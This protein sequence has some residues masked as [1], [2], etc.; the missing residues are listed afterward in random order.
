[1]PLKTTAGNH[2]EAAKGRGSTINPE[3]RFESVQRDSTDDGWFQDPGDGDKRPKTI[4]AIERAKSV[5]TKNDSPDIGFSQSLNPYRG[6]E[7]GCPYCVSGDTPIL[8]ANGRP[9][10]ISQVKVGDEIYGTVHFWR[11]LGHVAY[12]SLFVV[13]GLAWGRRTY[14]ARLLK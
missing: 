9:I 2:G 13:V 6:C 12:L 4:I 14:T 8:M 7:H 5:I 1:M 11:A 3:G 10:P